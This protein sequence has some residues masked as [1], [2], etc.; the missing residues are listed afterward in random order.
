M[1]FLS[2][3]EKF[4]SELLGATNDKFAPGERAPRSLDTVDP[5][6]PDKV[7][8]F[9]LLGGFA[10]NIDNSAQRSYIETGS[11]RN[12]RPRNLEI[13]M[14]EPDYTVIIKKR[15]FSSLI[16]NYKYELMDK[17]EKLFI[18][19]SKK[20]FQNKCQAISVYEKL[21][22]IEKV[23][24][25]K[26]VL[27][28]FMIP[29]L[30]SGIDAIDAVGLGKFI[31][32]KTRSVLNELRQL[33]LFSEPS[34]FTNWISDGNVFY[35]D[36]GEG[37]GVFELTLATSVSTTTSIKFGGGSANLTFE[38]PYR[39]MSVTE[40]DVD[41]AISDASNFFNNNNFFRVTQ[42]ETQKIT[43]DL[44]KKLNNDRL[45][46]GVP[47]INIF[48]SDNTLIYKRVRAVID[49]I[50]KEI[51]FNYDPGVLGIG[52]ILDIDSVGLGPKADLNDSEKKTFTDIIKN[53]YALLNL[54][55]DTV[56]KIKDFNKDEAITFV[57]EKMMLHYCGKSI[58]QPMDTV[59][60]FISSK[61]QIDS[62]ALGF[63]KTTFTASNYFTTLNSSL[64][65]LQDSLNN[66]SGYFGGNVQNTSLENEKN[67]IVGADFPTWLWRILRN[68]YTKQAAGVQVFSGVVNSSNGSYEASSGTYTLSV[69]V[70]DN[71]S[72]FS[73]GQINVKPA[74]DVFNGS[75]YDPLTPFKT[76][77]D[78]GSGFLKGETPDLLD[79][80]SK[81]A[82]SGALKFKNGRFR[83]TPFT[84]QKYKISDGER[85]N[86]AQ[87]VNFRK[88]L[89]DADGLVY[90]WKTG[91]GTLTKFGEPHA[92]SSFSPDTS[93]SLTANPFAGQD[94]MNVLSLLITG[95]PYNYN[96]FALAAVQSGNMTRDDLLNEDGSVSFYRGLLSDLTKNNLVWGNF[97]PFKEQ[98]ISDKGYSFLLRGQF[99]VSALNDKV[100]DLISQRAKL[101]D[102]L[103]QTGDGSRFANNPQIFSSD[104]NYQP[105][106][107]TNGTLQTPDTL[108]A[109]EGI[110]NFDRQIDEALSELHNKLKDANLNDGSLKI[111]GDDV[112]YDPSVADNNSL[113][114]DDQ[115][116]AR[117]EFR[118]KINYLT[119]RRLWKVKANNDSNLFIVDDQYDKNLDVQAF[120]K[121]LAG[122]LSLLQSDYSSVGEYIPRVKDELG[123]EVF[124]DT[125]GHIRAKPPGYNKVP[126]SVFYR[127]IKDASKS[128]KRIFPKMLEDMFLNQI[129]GLTDSLEINE[130]EIRLRM[131][132]LGFNT[133]AAAVPFLSGSSD[134]GGL[135]NYWFVFITNEQ[136]GKVGSTDLR[137]MIQQSSPDLR[138]SAEFRPLKTIT[139]LI[140]NQ[141][142]R[143]ALF[144]ISKKVQSINNPTVFQ[145]I[146]NNS[147]Y[148]FMKISNRL[149]RL[150]GITAP[151]LQSLFSTDRTR[152]QQTDVLNILNDVAR[153]ISERQRL[154]KTLSN[155]IKNV[156]QGTSVDRDPKAAKSLL[157]PMLNKKSTIPEILEHMI[158]DEDNDDLGP[159]SGGRYII[160][161]NQII[162]ISVREEPPQFTTVEVN[163]LYGEGF[164]QPPSSLNIN[165]VGGSGGNAITTAFAV[166]YDMWR[167]YGFKSSQPISNKALTDPDSQLAPLAVYL[168][169]L[170]RKNILQADATVVGNEYMQPGE[171]VYI[172][173]Y[174]LLFYVESVSH[175]ISFSG[176]NFTTKLSL[177]YGHNPGEYIPTM[178]DI[179]GKTLYSKRNQSNLIRHVR[180]GHPAGETPITTLTVDAITDNVDLALEPL[181]RLVAGTLGDQ[182]RKNLSNMIIAAAG[183]FTPDLNKKPVIELRIYFDKEHGANAAINL[184]ETAFAVK[185]WMINP[186]QKSTLIL[187][188]GSSTDQTSMLPDNKTSEAQTLNKDQFDI[189][190]KTID[191]KDAQSPSSA[192]WNMA[193]NLTNSNIV[194]AFTFSDI[195]ILKEEQILYSNIIDVWLTFEDATST[196]ATS[197]STIPVVNQSEAAKRAQVDELI[198]KRFT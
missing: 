20:L 144:D 117:Q 115:T 129:D 38:D 118:K 5:N 27:D 88:V 44:K 79:E 168:L 1:A 120:E 11:I 166:D 106:I 54:Q 188:G 100:N 133:D 40:E 52:A 61:T 125:Q 15:L 132:A 35:S 146:S 75:L 180:H 50:G 80:N 98:I 13:L 22:K 74:V 55:D 126:S 141:V 189:V 169:N 121:T 21:T 124:A 192:A 30:V 175:N 161:D 143:T 187:D 70:H 176:G 173:S 71:T 7:I 107:P 31:G 138:E 77:F 147:D 127:M 130:D 182:N 119:Q 178:L 47:P 6:D 185:E 183:A 177:I 128:G 105:T 33:S 112:S 41:K 193:R 76:D 60:V 83:G 160:K 10:K 86:G 145:N 114:N 23:V 51:F 194:K 159:G 136:T 34:Q 197:R 162:S 167:M 184:I 87:S 84:E 24:Q 103:I 65:N 163:G 29:Q 85:I 39:L 171:V 190:V 16:D 135:S 72:Y 152:I 90:R 170:A 28:D 3:I 45:E 57:R 157:F 134:L 92:Q 58:I 89:N 195:S 165:G 91:I 151:T 155:S 43:D 111:F 46:R 99:D 64:E 25:S 37:T 153:F 97:I 158:E 148:R 137:N 8:N 73:M 191:K 4:G 53:V 164:T 2:G 142:Q 109:A 122:N 123:L 96:T 150:K 49:E 156:E 48:T 36:L 18:S 140:A 101:F 66:F 186:S 63:T 93:P 174:N 116:R 68:D 32:S 198:R 82:I 94:V 196:V 69:G 67:A 139:G 12:I 62:K 104:P 108:E 42:D 17:A 131:A 14:Q 113:T 149:E 19:S 102:A 56:S 179:V 59:H 110:A 95:Q 172:E 81:L 9:G 26:G 154:L 78:A 181:K